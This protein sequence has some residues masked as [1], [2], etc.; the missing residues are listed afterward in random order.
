MYP[1]NELNKPEIEEEPTDVYNPKLFKGFYIQKEKGIKT[2]VMVYDATRIRVPL[3]TDKEYFWVTP[4]EILVLFQFRNVVI[5]PSVTYLFEDM[6]TSTE[7]I[8]KS[9][10]TL[11]RLSDNS[12]VPCPYVLFSCSK[13]TPGF[14]NFFGSSTEFENRIQEKTETVNL[15]TPTIDHPQLGRFPLFSALPLN[16]DTP[17]IQR[18]AVFVDIDGLEPTFIPEDDDSILDHL[19]DERYTKQYSSISFMY[20]DK[21]YW[22]VKS[23]FY[24]TEIYDNIETFIPISTFSEISSQEL[25]KNDK[26]Q[27][28]LNETLSNEG[29]YEASDD[30]GSD[31]NGSNEGTDNE[32]SNEGTDNEGS[33]EEEDKDSENEDYRRGYEAGI[34][35]AMEHPHNE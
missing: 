14:F 33:D 31:Y 19:Y 5:D 6:A 7:I 27:E 2:A 4:Y 15:I 9:F 17:H 21:Q 32:G 24:F 22:C 12:L 23:P 3:A 16:P 29:S 25:H 28:S 30:E 18:Y 20:K 11:K 1:P 34:K 26:K 35:E 8:D 10:Y 13:S